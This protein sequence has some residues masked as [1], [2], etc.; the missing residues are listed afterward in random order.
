MVRHTLV[1][2]GAGF[3]GTVLAAKLLRRPPPRPTDVVLIERGAAM[4]RGM[5]Y[6]NRQFP[7]LLNVPAARLSAD[8]EDPSQFLRFAQARLPDVDGEAFLPRALYGDYLNEVLLRAEGSAPEHVR[9]ARVFGEVVRV[10]RREGTETLAAE[11]A[12]R[13]ALAADRL[14]L[15][16]GNPPP[17]LPPWASRIRGHPAFRHDP[18]EERPNLSA[19]HAVLIIGNGLTMADVA[20]SLSQ[21]A[22]DTPM[23]YSISRRGLLPQQQV[24]FHAP[25]VHGTNELLLDCAQSIRRVLAASR[26][27]AR[28]AQCAGGDWREVVTSI[29][30]LA[31]AL[32]RRLPAIERKRFVRHLQPHWDVHRHRLPPQL[33]AHIESLRARGRLEVNAGRVMSALAAE[34]GRLQVSWQP[35]G[36]V[37]SRNVTVDLVINATGPDYALERSVD[38][39]MQSLR[40]SG[41]VSSDALNLGLRTDQNGACVDVE[42]AASDVLF[43]LGPMLR[44][45]HL[46]GGGR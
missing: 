10:T 39:L 38:P 43:Y 7:Y 13:P 21:D 31:P 3:C 26:G 6:A 8:A 42:G 9:L 5:A 36:G 14:I 30:H 12:D 35:R 44:A 45:G 20:A 25:A 11:F 2:V 37:D 29:R 24:A 28:E 41:W 33:A 34:G 32:W 23:L 15:A 19:R 46:A 1:I 18:W 17:V 4:G 40:D 22:A 16:S 27:L